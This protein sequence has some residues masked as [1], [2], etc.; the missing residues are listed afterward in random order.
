MD[1][2]GDYTP[3]GAVLLAIGWVAAL[4]TQDGTTIVTALT[5]IALAFGAGSAIRQTGW[6][7]EGRAGE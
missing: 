5:L 2:L 1:S 3:A 4:V 6:G 7:D